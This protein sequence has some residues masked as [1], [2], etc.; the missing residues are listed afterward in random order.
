[1]RKKIIFCFFFAITFSQ[2][3]IAQSTIDKKYVNNRIVQSTEHTKLGG[4]K[5][6]VVIKSYLF[7]EDKVANTTVYFTVNGKKDGEYKYYSGS[8]LIEHSIFKNGVL[9]GDNIRY[10][11]NGKIQYKEK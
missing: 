4:G 11:D 3:L 1:M 9:D 5:E 10:Y 8:N 2:A 7:S 6:Q